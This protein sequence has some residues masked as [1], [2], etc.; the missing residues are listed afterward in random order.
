MTDQTALEGL[1]ADLPLVDGH[2]HGFLAEDPL[3]HDPNRLLER[4]SY[5]GLVYYAGAPYVEE[6][7][8]EGIVERIAALAGDTLF[9]RLAVRWLAEYLDCEP[10]IGAVHTARHAA[11]ARDPAAYVADLVRSAGLAAVVADEGYPDD[12]VVVRDD[13]QKTLGIPVFRAW[14]MEHW[15]YDH[16]E[17]YGSFRDMEDAFVEALDLAAADDLTVAYKTIIA[18]FSGLAVEPQDTSPDEKVFRSWVADRGE[19]H[20]PETAAILGHFLHLTA[21]RAL[22]HS[23]PLHIHTGAGDLFME[24]IAGSRPELLYPFLHA[25]RHQAVVMIHA[26]Q[27]WVRTAACMAAS[28]PNVYIDL[29]E[30]L[31]WSGL[32]ASP[33]LTHLIAAVPTSKLMYG[34]DEAGEP[35]TLWLGARMARRS[36]AAALVPLVTDGTVTHMEAREIGAGILGRNCAALH[37][38]TVPTCRETSM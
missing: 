13:F 37:G 35:E 18:Y 15:I 16:A 21:D 20:S 23:L 24:S 38:I 9:G 22:M 29:S 36:L 25:R 31:P 12:P 33:D 5:L 26:G 10:T 14:R 30:W 27:P 4:L 32:A 34:S 8:K 11:L 2:C 6:T 28:L 1:L 3:R 19:H 7:A 17:D